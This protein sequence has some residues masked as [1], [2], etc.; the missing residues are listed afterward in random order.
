MYSAWSPWAPGM[1]A[2]R[3]PGI[4]SVINL[5]HTLHVSGYAILSAKG[6]VNPLASSTGAQP[7]AHMRF[8]RSQRQ[9]QQQH[10]TA[11][12]SACVVGRETKIASVRQRACYKRA[13]SRG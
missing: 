11:A 13:S 6:L 12:S 2:R 10:N 5:A 7:A 3:L 1:Q 9:D 8:Q 4:R